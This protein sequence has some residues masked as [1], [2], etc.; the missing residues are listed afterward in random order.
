MGETSWIEA[1][2]GRCRR[3]ITADEVASLEALGNELRCLRWTVAQLHRPA[4]AVRAQISVRQIEQI[5]R[6]IRR[7]RRSTLERIVAALV[8]VEPDLGEPAAL[9]ARLT[10]LAGIGLAPESEYRERVERRRRRRWRKKWT[11]GE[12]RT[13]GITHANAERQTLK[14]LRDA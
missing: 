4:L 7:T 1:E 12:W 6:A 3:P 10:E 13:R 2:R 5:E 11:R 14:E 9:V 8:K